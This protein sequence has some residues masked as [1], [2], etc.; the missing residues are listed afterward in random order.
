[1]KIKSVLLMSLVAA[2]SI[3]AE[4]SRNRQRES[5]QEKRIATGAKSGELTRHETKKLVRGQKKVDAY[6]NKASADGEVSIK[7]KAHLENMQDRQSKKIYHQKH[8]EQ[9]RRGQAGNPGSEIPSDP[10]QES[11]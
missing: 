7:E 6:Q 4:A 11:K 10:S 1:M 2:L 5:R 9:V 8:D 3:N